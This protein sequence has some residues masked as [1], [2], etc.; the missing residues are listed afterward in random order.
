MW[1]K[2]H[3]D[4]DNLSNESS[5]ARTMKIF[6]TIANEYHP[7]LQFKLDIQ[8][9]HSSNR[10]PMLDLAVWA[11]TEKDCSKI[12]GTR[13]VICHSF[14]E[15]DCVSRKVIEFKSAIQHRSKIVSLSQEVK[16]RMT[17]TDRKVSI[18]ERIEIIEK[19][20]Y[21]MYCSSYPEHVR[22]DIMTKKTQ[23]T[24]KK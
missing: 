8:E 18:Q 19:F 15:K 5:A 6:E 9:N 22:L 3:E 4:E 20:A 23:K 1:K 11:T 12:E 24:K 13:E 16:R 17:N 2:E 14:Y 21:K 10:V 7:S